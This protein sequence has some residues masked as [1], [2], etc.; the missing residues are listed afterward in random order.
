MTPPS[1]DPVHATTAIVAVFF[2]PTLAA[3]V[4][5]YAVIILCAS[6]GSAWSLGRRPV[7]TRSG[8]FK[9]FLLMSG[10]ALVLTVP[11]AQ[12]LGGWLGHDDSRWLFSPVALLIGGVGGDWPKLL[13]WAGGRVLRLIERRAGVD[14]DGGEK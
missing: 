8:A 2:G 3:Y 14:V 10:T 13:T 6:V 11:L 7:T 1:L 9:Y 12:W 4:G 5:P